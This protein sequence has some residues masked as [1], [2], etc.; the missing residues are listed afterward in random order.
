MQNVCRLLWIAFLCVPFGVSLS[1]A[2][3]SK[4]EGNQLSVTAVFRDVDKKTT[5]R[6]LP[7]SEKKNVQTLRLSTGDIPPGTVSIDLCH[8]YAEAKSGE[9]G[10]FVFSN[11]MYGTFNNDIKNGTYRNA[12]K[13]MPVF[14]V[15]TPRGAMAVIV[16][17]LPYEADQYVT[18]ENRV[19][20]VFPRF[21]LTDIV[22]YEDIVVEFHQ[23]SNDA[24]YSTVAKCYRQYQLDRQAVRPIRE[25]M[26]ERPELRY[27]ADAVEVRVRMGWKP[28]PSPVPEQTAETEPPMKVAITLDRVRDIFREFQKQKIDKA[29]FCLVGWNTK[30]HDGRYPQIFPVEPALGGESKLRE[31]IAD[32]K[33]YHYQLVCHTNSSDAYSSSRIG[34]LWDEGYL[35]RDK[36]GKPVTKTTYGGGNMYWTCPKCIFERFTSSDFDRL[37][38]LGF[39]GLHYIDVLSTVNPRDCWATDHPLNKK[40]YAEWANRMMALAEKKF[41]GVASEGGYDWCISHLDYSLCNSFYVPGSKLPQLVRRHVPFWELVYHGIVLSTPFRA[42]WNPTLE[43][44][45]FQLKLIEYGGRPVYYYYAKFRS[46]GNRQM[47]END[48]ECAT[49]KE[50]VHSVTKIKEGVDKFG[51]LFPLQ[52]EM[53]EEHS[54][55]ASDVVKTRYSDGT[56]IV[57]NYRAES[58]EYSGVKVPGMDYAIIK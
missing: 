24:T 30:G 18:V 6:S 29:E 35:L 54:E 16:T 52:T 48:L 2:A 8:P 55:I 28:V 7:L 44:R 50:L 13:V 41:G 1:V 14:G 43:E 34:G 4:P 23:L 57:V 17:G 9:E 46:A 21:Q 56:V 15:R 53:L 25:R 26:K 11:G 58:F 31:A 27:A 45:F 20:K 38:E 39:R 51:F 19:W 3:A 37:A 32:A 49:E 33:K 12:N 40:G 22:P 42:V 5:V 47:G 36:E 10:F